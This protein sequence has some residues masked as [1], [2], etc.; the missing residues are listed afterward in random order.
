MEKGLHL[1][2]ALDFPVTLEAGRPL[3]LLLV[4]LGVITPRWWWWRRD[5]RTDA[6][7]R[8]VGLGAGLLGPT[9]SP[10]A[11]LGGPKQ[12]TRRRDAACVASPPPTPR[13]HLGQ[14]H[15][16]QP[17]C[18]CPR[19]WGPQR[20]WRWKPYQWAG[21]L[22]PVHRR[23]ESH[24]GG[25]GHR[26]GEPPRRCRRGS[27]AW[28]GSLSATLDHRRAPGC[29]GEY[30]GLRDKSFPSNPSHQD[31]QLVP[32]QIGARPAL[33]PADVVRAGEPTAQAWPPL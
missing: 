21:D 8:A 28:P 26:S 18:P 32:R 4:P 14:R 31:C 29:S 22:Q 12:A 27:A 11:L 19:G 20:D 3:L 25:P 10:L 1:L 33:D 6:P 7:L 16:S 23:S 2:G 5:R 30:Q 9:S 24:G 17:L 15:C 13:S